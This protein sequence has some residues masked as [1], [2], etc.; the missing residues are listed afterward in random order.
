MPI[1]TY[2]I[3]REGE[4]PRETFEIIQKMSDPPLTTH[5]ETGEPVRRLISAPRFLARGMRGDSVNAETLA[6]KGFT[7]YEKVG[8]GTYE[9]TA[10][11]QGPKRFKKP[12]P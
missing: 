5:P 12:G 7:R 10:G 3:L 4:A 6:R 2:E 8:D 9:R 1:Y 11:S